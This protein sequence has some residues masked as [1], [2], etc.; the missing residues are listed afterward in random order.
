MTSIDSDDTTTAGE[1]EAWRPQQALASIE[2]FGASVLQMPLRPYQ[3]EVARAILTS[4]AERRGHTITVLM[5]RQSGKNQ[6]SAHLEAYLLIRRLRAGGSLVKCAPTYQPQVL[7]STARLTAALDNPLTRGHWHRRDGHIIALGRASIAFFSAEPGANVVGATAS[8]LLEC[9]EAQDVLPD[10]WE[11]DFRPMGATANAT[12]VLYGT[13][14][15]DD[16]L[17]AR[18]IAANRE[19]EAYDG[20]RRHFQV[21]W[22]DVARANPAYGQHVQAEI[23]RLGEHHP[24]VRTQYL[25]RTVAGGGRFLDA[26]QV[27]RLAGEH[28]PEDGPSTWRRGPG[29]YVAGIDV[30]GEDEEDPSGEA[31][32]VN[33]RRDSTVLTIAYAAQARVS[34]RV[35]EPRFEVVRQ[36]AWRGDRHRELY[37]RIQALV[38][39][40]WH[41]KTVVVDATGVGGGLAAFLAAALGP[42]IVTPFRYT[43]ASK[44]Q[45]AY[46]FLAA[47]NAGRFTV[48][49]ES[50]NP[51]AN[52]LRRE[53]LRQCEVA[54]YA[55]RANQVMSFF[56]PEHRGH[57][58]LLNAAALAVQAQPLGRVRTATGHRRDRSEH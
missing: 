31:V 39:D 17:L 54:E 16:T 58:D 9:D 40:H 18:Q 7:V 43:A 45:L 13:P 52:D 35:I 37:P 2:A 21:D 48:H 33:P 57:D 38:G 26:G 8:L 24:I 29:G 50:A 23:A 51:E 56:V 47:V 46:D 49:A 53:L 41:C 42:A 36:Y 6:L 32:H 14:W 30:A 34:E 25:L 10:K 44:S 22:G 55:M 1:L 12:S 4:I 5:P 19:A 3:L 15:T 11:K 27:A 20:I 28:A